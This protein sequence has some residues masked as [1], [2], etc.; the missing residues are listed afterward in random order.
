MRFI[1]LKDTNSNSIQNNLQNIKLIANDMDGTLTQKGKF[2]SGLL[3]LFEELERA[4]IQVL[5][6]TGRSA[7][8]VSRLVNYLPVAGAI[9]ENGGLF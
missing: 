9:A 6:V 4:N 2:S 3:R 7:G 8:W 1:L 5:I